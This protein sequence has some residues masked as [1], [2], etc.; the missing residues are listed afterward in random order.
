MYYHI[1]PKSSNEKTG[2]L[3]VTTSA[4]D[5]CPPACPLKLTCYAKR[6]FLGLFWRKVS[7]GKHGERFAEFL[8]SL[9]QALAKNPAPIWRHNQAGDLP[10]KGDRINRGELMALASV[11]AASGKQGFTYTHK[12]VRPEDCATGSAA[13]RKRLALA[14]LSAVQSAFAVGF[15]I[16]LSANNLAH[17][18]SLRALGLPVCVT[19]PQS[20][21]ATFYTPAGAKGIICPAQT[22]SGVS[23]ATCRLCANQRRNVL[24][25]FRFHGSGAAH[26]AKETGVSK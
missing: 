16:N 4:S 20:T 8:R 1:S 7:A 26:G 19:V 18:D 6:S 14:N 11:S 10:G 3:V 15:T 25:G 22:R 13:Q 24:I 12:P 17:A 21:P 5:T 23:C 2:A 9:A